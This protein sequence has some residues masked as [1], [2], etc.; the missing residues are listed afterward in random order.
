MSENSN[1]RDQRVRDYISLLHSNQPLPLRSY[2]TN[3]EAQEMVGA[4]PNGGHLL[5]ADLD[6]RG[7]ACKWRQA[8]EDQIRGG[9]V[10]S[11]WSF[12][13]SARLAFL[14]YG[15]CYAEGQQ[16]LRNE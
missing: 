9:L 13:H 11:S 2:L 6:I 8:A 12:W 3:Q 7:Y 5:I 15:G 10:P 16:P 4:C 1:V 14:E